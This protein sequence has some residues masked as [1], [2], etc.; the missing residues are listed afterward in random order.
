M[1]ESYNFTWSESDRSKLSLLGGV[2]VFFK[3][4]EGGYEPQLRTVAYVHRDH[5]FLVIDGKRQRFQSVPIS[6]CDPSSVVDR[7]TMEEIARTATGSAA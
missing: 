2:V 3:L 4:V 1:T 6:Q 7:S 5:V